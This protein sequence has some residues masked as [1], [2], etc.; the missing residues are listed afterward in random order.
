[1]SLPSTS[2]LAV[3]SAL[4]A[5]F[6]CHAFKAHVDVDE[7][8]G[9]DFAGGVDPADQLS[10]RCVDAPGN[11]FSLNATSAN[12]SVGAADAC[13]EEEEDC[14]SA[15]FAS[16]ETH[17]DGLLRA[18]TSSDFVEHGR[19]VIQD[20]ALG[21]NLSLNAT[22]VNSS[23]GAADACDEEEEDCI[24][25]RVAPALARGDGLHKTQHSGELGLNETAV[26]R[27]QPHDLFV[28]QPQQEQQ[29]QGRGQGGGLDV[30]DTVQ[31]AALLEEQA[32]P[33]LPGKPLW[34]A[35]ARNAVMVIAVVS[36]GISMVHTVSSSLE[37]VWPLMG[38]RPPARREV[39][40]AAKP[41]RT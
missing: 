2:L 31:E 32:V 11:N 18:H 36:F 25:A 19:L 17:V 40:M 24:S 15:R 7:V 1:M 3:L 28:Q 10:D 4:C 29:Q 23:A 27:E 14:F 8:L 38:R 33:P 26:I 9:E 35:Y 37:T 39:R 12:F 13:D 21:I 22:P 20:Q 6:Q 41:T 5:L 34:R 30:G 16:S